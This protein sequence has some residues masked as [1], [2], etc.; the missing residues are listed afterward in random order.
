MQR[1]RTRLPRASTSLYKA[2]GAQLPAA[3]S[4]VPEEP[5]IPA[6]AEAI[7]LVTEALKKLIAIDAH[8]LLRLGGSANMP[9]ELT[10]EC[11]F[12]PNS[13]ISRSCKPLSH[14]LTN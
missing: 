7:Q 12:V 5:P 13:Q 4:P 9:A 1:P 10:F 8:G 2:Q 3:P 6:S 11:V 14:R